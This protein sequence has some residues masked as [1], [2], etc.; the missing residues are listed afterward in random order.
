M[1]TV[2]I[3]G[4]GVAGLTVAHEL[5][6]RGYTVNLFEQL[7]TLGG[8]ARSFPDPG[9]GQGGRSDL[10][11]EHGFRFYPG[12][13][14]HVPD[15]MS[16]IPLPGGGS[17]F[18]NLRNV[19]AISIAF[20]NA[21][22]MKMA[23]NAS[24]LGSPEGWGLA[25]LDLLSSQ[26]VGLSLDDMLFFANRMLCAYASCEQR[27]EQQ[28]EN[29]SWQD[30]IK[31]SQRGA[32]YKRVFCNGLSRPL[33][34]LDPDSCNART[35]L[36]VMLQII[37]DMVDPNQTADRVLN[38]PTTDAWINPWV[39]Y[40]GG[41]GN[42]AVTFGA[43]ASQIVMTNGRVDHVV[44][45]TNGGQQNVNADYYVFAVPVDVMQGLVSVPMITAAPELAGMLSL[46]TA[47]MTGLVYYYS[48]AVQL[49]EGHTIY[50]DSPWALTSISELPFWHQ[51]N[52][53][54]IGAGNVGTIF[55]TII[56]NWDT[57]GVGT[58]N[59][60]KQCTQPQLVQEAMLQINAHR[61]NMPGGTLDNTNL[62]TTFLDP[63]ISFNS[64]G[65][66]SGNAEQL[67]IN[68][69]SSYNLRPP[70]ATRIPN[71]FLAGDYVQTMTNLATMEGA[72]EAGR[73]A[74]LGVLLRD[75]WNAG[76]RP[77]LFPLVEPA[78]FDGFKAFDK[79]FCFPFGF[80]PPCPTTVTALKKHLK[81]RNRHG[82]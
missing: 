43:T 53:G 37:Q 77:Q 27:R 44:V 55:S 51:V 66:V 52:G 18:D 34:A 73:A 46:K 6:E 41:L 65:V 78:I 49:N 57:P 5:G 63:A 76:P 7:A 1:A 21:P 33:V 13:Y 80:P 35:A 70:P 50:A 29:M 8:K 11:G 38:G 36:T 26:Q 12:F 64:A 24:N 54:A 69:V 71:L 40:L 61:Q 10:P 3:I 20:D 81:N 16:R 72:C 67:L 59:T 82:R 28:Y 23:T 4:G 68:T 58:P 39:A 31:V 47:W 45:Q 22:P 60:A 15:T 56:S 9:T 79:T 19:P 14:K 17:V 32:A 48:N 25:M 75:G 2:A 74:A 42:V 30:Y 62:L